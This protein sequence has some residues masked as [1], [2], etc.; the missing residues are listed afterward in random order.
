MS[1]KDFIAQKTSLLRIIEK[2]IVS[3]FCPAGGPVLR[4]LEGQKYEGG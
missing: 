2:V 4:N 1:I 3:V